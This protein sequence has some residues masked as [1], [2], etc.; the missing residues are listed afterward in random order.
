MDTHERWIHVLS[1]RK[2]LLHIA[3][4]RL[5]SPDDA[6]D[7]VQEAM[8]RAATFDDLD[9]DR[10]GQFLTSVT[11]RLCADERRRAARAAYLV[12]RVPVDRYEEPGVDE[13]IC[14]LAEATWAAGV[15]ASLPATQ[16][17]VLRGRADGLSYEEIGQRRRLSF[18]S[19]ESAAARARATVRRA[20]VATLS[21][22]WVARR[23]ARATAVVAMACGTAVVGSHVL[24]RV[25]PAPA[26]ILP[27]SSP[28]PTTR[29]FETTRAQ[30][31]PT[32]GPSPLHRTVRPFVIPV[33]MFTPMM[34]R[35]PRVRPS[36][37]ADLPTES[38]QQCLDDGPD[39]VTR[40]LRDCVPKSGGGP[41]TPL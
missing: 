36:I 30:T 41:P 15:V 22:T 18:K 9:E 21:V 38:P 39:R 13:Q 12:R 17:E 32:A 14:A 34:P 6:E 7:I 4:A 31:P 25:V 16:Q 37:P 1:H 40:I 24:I 33:P 8:I 35:P 11:V 19:V 10:L 28:S 26:L 29:L 2:R 3:R 20:L 5:L 23:R 27:A